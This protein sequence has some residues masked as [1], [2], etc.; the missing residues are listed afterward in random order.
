MFAA[1]ALEVA[2]RYVDPIAIVNEA[3]ELQKTLTR[4]GKLSK[5][6]EIDAVIEKT[7]PQPT[8]CIWYAWIYF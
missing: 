1:K 2:Q 7:Y 3:I 8:G 4:N 6:M 5:A